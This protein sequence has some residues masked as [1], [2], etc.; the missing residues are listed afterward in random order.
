MNWIQK[1][2]LAPRRLHVLK[3]ASFLVSNEYK[4]S[5]GYTQLNYDLNYKLNHAKKNLYDSRYI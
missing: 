1:Q 3:I 4:S 2:Y 5:T